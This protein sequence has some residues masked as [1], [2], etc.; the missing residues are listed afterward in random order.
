MEEH[1]I[2]TVEVME[3]DV[4]KDEE[5]LEELMQSPE[6]GITTLKIFLFPKLVHQAEKSL[7]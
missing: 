4:F 3:T 1:E 6:L 2:D 7:I 5:V